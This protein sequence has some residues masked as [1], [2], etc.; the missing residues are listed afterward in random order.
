M[1]IDLTIGMAAVSDWPGVWATITNLRMNHAE[2]LP[3]CELIVVDNAPDSP[4]GEA[5][6]N[7]LNWLKPGRSNDFAQVR[8]V[9]FP[10]PKGTAAP[11]QHIF[12]IAEGK[13][14]LC[15]DSHV[16]PSHDS[17]WKLLNQYLYNNP[18]TNDLL[19]G[20]LLYDDL[21]TYASH[22]ADEWR[23]KMWG[24]W[25]CDPRANSVNDEPFEVW[26]Q[27]LGLF[28]CLKET[29]QSVGGFNSR[30]RGFGGEEGYIHEKFRQHGG[31]VMCLPFLRWAHRF[32]HP[33]GVP[34]ANTI[35]DRVWNYVV[36]HRELGLSLDRCRHH[37]T[38][39]GFSARQFDDIA[40]MEALTPEEAVCMTRSSPDRLGIV[41]FSTSFGQG[42]SQES[43]T[44]VDRED[45]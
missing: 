13:W 10:T 24:T 43:V 26:G 6:K 23:D 16:M 35:E 40:R 15:M 20:V 44:E 27:G 21:T 34:Y 1:N 19:S 14:V 33:G 31:K 29:W 7:F 32:G 36:G 42:Y 25:Q 37:F 3:Q 45:C 41:Q 18:D 11:R 9:P 4:H 8:Y 17:L 22:F 30:F 2:V 5:V 38:S 39:N 28:A 12:D